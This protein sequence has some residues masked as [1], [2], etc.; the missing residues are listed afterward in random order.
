MSQLSVQPVS[1]SASGAWTTSARMVRS[2]TTPGRGSN[3][4]Q[5]KSSFR[6]FPRDRGDV[7]ELHGRLHSNIEVVLDDVH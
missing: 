6:E 5:M 7:A 3:F 4:T 1:M 2:R